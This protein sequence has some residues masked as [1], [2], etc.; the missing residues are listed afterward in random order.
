MSRL[1]AHP[2]FLQRVKTFKEVNM[3]FL[4]TEASAFHLD[5]PRCLPALFSTRPDGAAMEEV[6]VSAGPR[7]IGVDTSNSAPRSM[8]N[9]PTTEQRQQPY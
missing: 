2:A 5:M 9:Q 7:R 3:N 4:A 6:R 8:T 1:A